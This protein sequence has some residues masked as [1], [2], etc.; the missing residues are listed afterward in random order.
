MTRPE[1]YGWFHLTFFAL[2]ILGGILLCKFFKEGTEKQVR[3]VIL[4]V[5]I[6]VTVLEIYKQIN[7]TF[8][9]DG[10]TVVTD[11]QWYI[12]PWQFCSMPMYVGLLAGA[13]KQGKL[14]DALC[15]FLAT[16]AVFAGCCVMFYPVSVFIETI[17]INVQ[18]MICHG[19]MITVGM[20]LLYTGYVKAEQKTMLKALPVFCVAVGIAVGLNEIAHIAGITERETFN[21]FFVSPHEDPSLPVYSMVQGIVPYPWCLLIYVTAFSLA[22]YIILLA[23]MGIKKIVEKKAK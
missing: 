21:M 22:A 18:T 10:T 2:S 17:G 16:Y 13:T 4:T 11:Y 3:T 19:S 14:H 5:A 8:V 1:P 6:T 12:F 20:Y 7:Y 9:S 15:A 23:V